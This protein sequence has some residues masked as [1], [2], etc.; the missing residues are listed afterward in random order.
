MFYLAKIMT[1]VIT[2]FW[3]GFLEGKSSKKKLNFIEKKTEETISAYRKGRYSPKKA[4]SHLSV[5]EK[6][7]KYLRQDSLV[8]LRAVQAQILN[9][10][11]N[12]ITAALYASDSIKLG[13]DAFHSRNY[14]AWKIL[15]NASLSHPIDYLISDL[16]NRYANANKN[17]KFFE[18]NWNYFIGNALLEKNK[19]STAYRYFSKLKM[20]DRYYLPAQYQM[21]IIDIEKDRLEDAESRLKAILNEVPQGLSSLN[22]KSIDNIIDYTSMALGRLYYEQKNFVSSAFYY[23]KVPK[24]SSLFYDSLFEQSW[25]LFMS[26]RPKH[27]LGSLYGAH[28]PYFKNVYNPEGKVL[29]SMIYFWMCRYDEARNALADFVSLYADSVGG[30]KTFL[31]RQ[32]LTP[33]TTYR[34]F[35][36]LITGVSSKSLGISRQVLETASHRNSMLMVRRNYAGIVEEQSKIMRDGMFGTKYGVSQIKDRLDRISLQLRDQIGSTYLAELRYL[37]DHYEDLYSQAQFLYLELLMSQKEHLLGRE[38]HADTK[39]RKVNKRIKMKTWAK[40]TQSWR[41]EKAEYWWD[42]IGFQIIDLDP[43]CN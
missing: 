34:L 24:E 19:P 39:V 11:K 15:Y 21:A 18:N 29:E 35:E 10:E 8:R 36:N 26:G 4:W 7:R 16:A 2:T 14:G 30:L 22:E 28:T 3:M 12:Y 37:K 27:A 6:K 41:D 5:L 17:P 31:E 38:L 33:E 32:R 9:N 42:E 13:S 43:I 25:A 40:N 23:R 1:L 20:S